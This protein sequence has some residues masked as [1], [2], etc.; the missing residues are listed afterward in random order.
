MKQKKRMF[1]ISA[2]AMLLT[3]S[4]TQTVTI[5]VEATELQQTQDDQYYLF[6][7]SSYRLLEYEDISTISTADIRIAKNEI[8]ARHGRK[9]SSEDLQQYFSQLPWYQGTIEPDQFDENSLNEIERANVNFLDQE[10]QK[11]TGAYNASVADSILLRVKGQSEALQIAVI[12]DKI[13]MDSFAQR[14]TVQYKPAVGKIDEEEPATVYLGDFYRKDGEIC[15]NIGYRLGAD[16]IDGGNASAW[17]NGHWYE[18]VIE[19]EEY[20]DYYQTHYYMA[21]M[22]MD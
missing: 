11:G 12:E 19:S 5:P 2:T 7:D 8:Y 14:V 3:A 9:F 18:S 13:G 15:G 6:E 20:G 17:Y 22:K 10:Y 16:R 1:V 21:Y 4:I